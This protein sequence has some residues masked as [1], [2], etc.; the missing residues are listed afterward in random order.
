MKSITASQGYWRGCRV[1]R[2]QCAKKLFD[3]VNVKSVNRT[4]LLDIQIGGAVSDNVCN[5]LK[6]TITVGLGF[7]GEKVTRI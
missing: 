6:L 3:K 2:G 7:G 1:L 5:F 4:K